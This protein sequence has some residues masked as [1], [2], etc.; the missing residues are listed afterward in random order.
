M[1]LILV[2]HHLG[3]TIAKLDAKCVAKYDAKS[4]VSKFSIQF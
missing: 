1:T 3:S 4:L 2:V